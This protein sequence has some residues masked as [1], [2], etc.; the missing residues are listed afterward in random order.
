[1]KLD[2]RI[3]CCGYPV[4]RER[5]YK[6]FKAIEIQDTFY[7]KKANIWLVEKILGARAS[8][9]GRSIRIKGVGLLN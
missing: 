6:I 2:L 7:N 3:G 8:L 1:M 9:K 4:A 5:Y